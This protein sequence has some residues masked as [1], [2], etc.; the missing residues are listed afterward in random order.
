MARQAAATFAARA[1]RTSTTSTPDRSIAAPSLRERPA[2]AIIAAHV[3]AEPP[4]QPAGT[5]SLLRPSLNKLL[6]RPAA[7][8]VRPL[9]RRLARVFSALVVLAW[10]AQMGLLLRHQR[11]Q[12]AVALAA[13]LAGYGTAAQWRGVYYRGEKIGFSVSQTTPTPTGYEMREDGKLQMTLLGSTSAV[14]LASRL[15]VDR[16]F[17][18]Q[19]FSF[20][21]DPGSGPTEIEGA[22]LGTRLR[23]TIRTPSG[24]RQEVR[25]LPE[26][27]ALSVNLPRTLAARGLRTGDVH[28]VSVFDPATLRN[29]TMRLEVRR[30]ELVSVAGRPLPAFLVESSFAGVRTR[31]WI[32]DTGEIVREE[33]PMGLLVVRESPGRAQALAVPGSVQSDLLEAA[34]IVPTRA[35]RIDD[36]AAVA[37]L[38][39]RLGGL[40][41][42]D[43]RDLDGD[44][45]RLSGDELTVTDPRDLA[46]AGRP[47]DLDPYLRAEAFVESDAPEI[48]AEARKAAAGATAP[49]LQA[50]RLV[51]YVHALLEKKPTLSL[52]SAL[53]VLKT[54]VGD[55]NEHT[56]LYVAMARALGLPARIVV[57]LV[58]LRGAFYYHAWPEVFVEDPPGR[59]LWLPVDPTLDQFPADATHL[60]LARGGLERQAAILG[61]VG[62]ARIDV[63][64]VDLRPGA[65]P[66][67]VGR[68][69]SDLRPLQLDLPRRVH[70]TCWVQ[71]LMR[72]AP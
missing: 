61:L 40:E 19:R 10:V 48:V 3:L 42:F 41:G 44:G 15:Q 50:E 45:Q 39:L 60:R 11:A 31:S 5:S 1:G 7:A 34:A 36:T 66:I 29:T 52:P 18:L 53:E 30:R 64:G 33:S 57:G 17:N 67:L 21:L 59:G 43:R 27:P 68:P 8:L 4:P 12:S 46:A 14:R 28:T 72:E 38:R 20:A 70:G 25:E 69:A 13:D 71:R 49:R 55:C 6:G 51:R 58:Y 63:L 9:P 2:A 35:T 32:T 54:R 16:A 26:V 24:A 23:L 22:L 56:T 65:N 62:H 37:R 47:V